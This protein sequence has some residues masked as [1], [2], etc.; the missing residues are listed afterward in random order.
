MA[1][2]FSDARRDGA[3]TALA[4]IKDEGKVAIRPA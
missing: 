3:L 1:E 4:R 2:D